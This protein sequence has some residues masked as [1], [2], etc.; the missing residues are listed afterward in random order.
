[1][2]P[3]ATIAEVRARA[4]VVRVVGRAVD[5]KKAGTLFKGLCP[6]H[7]ERTPS[8]T[9]SPTR[10]TYHCFGCG[11]HGDALRFLTEHEAMSFPEAVRALAAEV[12]VEVPESRAESPEERQAREAKRSLT[13]RLLAAQ[14]KITAHFTEALFGPRGGAARAYLKQRGITRRTAEAFR[15]GWASGDKADFA[16]FL[17]ADGDVALDDLVTLGLLVPPDEGFREGERL[18]GGYLRFRER[19][20][21]PVVDL[22]GE[23]VGFSGRILDPHKKAAKYINS[24]ETPVFTKGEHLYG[25][26]TARHAARRAGR[27]VLCEGN[28]DV[29]MVYQA[30]IEG[31]AAAMGTALTPAQVRLVK[32]LSE[33]VVCV[34][35]GDAAGAKA[36][37]ASLVPFLEAGLQPRAVMLPA[38]EDPDSFVRAQGLEAFE[39][40]VDAAPPL[41]D[42]YITR[43]GDDH[44]ADPPGRV[45]AL[46]HV[47]PALAALDDALT[48][49]LYR[50]KVAEALAVDGALVDQAIEDA[51]R[52]AAESRARGAGRR[53]A[54]REAPAPRSAP[55]PAP[56]PPEVPFEV[57][58]EPP[59]PFE[60]APHHDE[61]P[62]PFLGDGPAAGGPPP[63]DLPPP[64]PEVR[65]L[66]VP[67]YAR[68]LFEFIVQYPHLAKRLDVEDAHICLTHA[69]LAGFVDGLCREVEAGR[70][71]N[72]DRLLSNLRDAD[73]VAF[74][75]EC[76]AR[77]PS[78]DG[79]T[80]EQ[81]FDDAHRRVRLG[82]L[83]AEDRR[84][85]DAMR[86]AWREDRA[87]YVE[88]AERLK[89]IR[90][91]LKHL[92]SPS[93]EGAR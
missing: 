13:A 31:V 47:A 6:F 92:H 11:A 57:H 83:E 21:F 1:L 63:A 82:S 51:K 93:V 62:P 66:R 55:T 40:L 78:Q 37:F 24:P 12:G 67:R 14:D 50:S 10:N 90:V 23:V 77:R 36:A 17:E 85:R 68:E 88:L 34:M 30:G 64:P 32:R 4:D 59:P 41:L 86:A 71:P 27:L 3:D 60:P 16:R 65:P 79:S 2:I 74:L 15:L 75:R 72:V 26:H 80:I 45:A 9:V 49:N 20:M 76:Q 44:P 39:A 69:G 87:A 19:V 7:E 81:A 61:P 73:V 42:L 56:P 43:A 33:Q 28:V 35:D 58:L 70:T 8:F 5:L 18:G 22:R 25:A 53:S 52:A 54:L 46:R 48:L 38:G 84:I 89:S 29:V 91:Q